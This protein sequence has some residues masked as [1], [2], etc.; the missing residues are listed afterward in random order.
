MAVGGRGGVG[1]ELGRIVTP[2]GPIGEVG[3]TGHLVPG[4]E[5]EAVRRVSVELEPRAG[6]DLLRRRIRDGPSTYR[7]ILLTLVS[8][9]CKVRAAHPEFGPLF[10]V[11]EGLDLERRRPAG[12]QPDT[13]SHGPEAF[14]FVSWLVSPA[15]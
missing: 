3:K 14:E 6:E 11:P 9:T 15:A 2:P 8:P 7:P 12:D 10:V 5:D 4:R 13:M 1:D